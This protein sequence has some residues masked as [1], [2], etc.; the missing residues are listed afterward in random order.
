ML[1]WARRLNLRAAHTP[2][3]CRVR[4]SPKGPKLG[5][6]YLPTFK[7]LHCVRTACTAFP[8]Q[9]NAPPSVFCADNW[10]AVCKMGPTALADRETMK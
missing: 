5:F 8:K 1:G 3:A 9:R 7:T 6:K 2:R 4:C 10:A